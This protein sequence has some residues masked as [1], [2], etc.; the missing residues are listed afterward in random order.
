MK[1][2]LVDGKY[3]ARNIQQEIH[4]KNELGKKYWKIILGDTG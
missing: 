4:W 2:Y 1:Q 3:T